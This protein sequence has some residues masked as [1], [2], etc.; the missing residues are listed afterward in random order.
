VSPTAGFADAGIWDKDERREEKRRTVRTRTSSI[1][2]HVHLV[3][4]RQRSSHRTATPFNSIYIPVDMSSSSTPVSSTEAG[5]SRTSFKAGNNIFTSD[6][7][8]LDRF[9][10]LKGDEEEKKRVQEALQR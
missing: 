8:F 10:K 7:S 9:R 1:G 3:S 6:G 2:F 5:T 4:H